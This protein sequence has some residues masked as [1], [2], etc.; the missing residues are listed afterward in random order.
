MVPGE[1]RGRIR[2]GGVRHANMGCQG[3][4]RIEFSIGVGRYS[5]L[6]ADERQTGGGRR[7]EWQQN[8]TARVVSGE[9]EITYLVKSGYAGTRGMHACVTLLLADCCLLA[10]GC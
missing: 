10:A 3:G 6:K 7:D 2:F 1:G 9:E 4:T 8:V 5:S